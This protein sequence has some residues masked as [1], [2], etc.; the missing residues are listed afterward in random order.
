MMQALVH[1]ADGHRLVLTQIASPEPAPGEV[2]IR[3]SNA[4]VNFLDVAYREANLTDGAVPGVD[5]AGVV[6]A[7]AAD[8][9]GPP[10]GARVTSFG[11]GGAWAELRAVPVSDLAVVP[12]RV[13]LSAAAALPGAAVTALQSVRLLGTLLGRRVLVTGASGG[14][15]RFAVQLAAMAGAEVVALVGSPARAAGLLELGASEIVT[16]VSVAAPFDDALDMVGGDRLAQIMAGLR[17]GGRAVSIGQ[18]SRQTSDLDLEA[19][20]RRGGG[21]WLTPFTVQT[22]FGPDLDLLLRL[23]ADGKLDPVIGWRGS[24]SR[25]DEATEALQ[26]RR[27]LGKAVLEIG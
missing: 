10:V 23:V 18:S 19:E 3:V 5:A 25:I 13:D 27:L 16:D 6:V 14:V 26:S 21:T 4:A 7:A 9:S 22:P 8:G 11:A 12:D 20:R 1:R 15:G 24:W 17:Q 2:L